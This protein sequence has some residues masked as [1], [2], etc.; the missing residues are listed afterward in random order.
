MLPKDDLPS[1]SRDLA[2][3]SSTVEPGHTHSPI[4]MRQLG[5][6]HAVTPKR[7]ALVAITIDGAGAIGGLQAHISPNKLT[8]T[9]GRCDEYWLFHR[10]S[11]EA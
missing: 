6:R 8:W 5:G 4:V 7:R 11:L 1:S 10:A 3:D 2:L 9:G